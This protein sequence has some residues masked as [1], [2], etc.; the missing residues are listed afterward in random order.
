[1]TKEGAISRDIAVGKSSV[2]VSNPRLTVGNPS[3]ITPFTPPAM[4]NVAEM[5][6]SERG[7]NTIS[8]IGQK[9]IGC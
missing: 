6:K 1:M 2:A 5:T 9:C 7:S 4:M 8:R 3:P